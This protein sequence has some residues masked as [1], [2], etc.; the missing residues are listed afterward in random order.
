MTGHAGVQSGLQKFSNH[1]AILF[2]W[3]LTENATCG[4][5][6]TINKSFVSRFGAE[7]PR[8]DAGACSRSFASRVCLGIFFALARG[9]TGKMRVP[10]GMGIL[11]MLD[12]EEVS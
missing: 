7:R 11:P 1:E 9:D 5:L 6:Q 3:L 8:K 10:R 2:H 12:S 4:I